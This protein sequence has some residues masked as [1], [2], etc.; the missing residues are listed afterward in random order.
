MATTEKSTGA[1]G[2]MMEVPRDYIHIGDVSNWY[3]GLL[4]PS[5]LLACDMHLPVHGVHMSEIN[6]SEATTKIA[7]VS[8]KR[9]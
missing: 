7:R 5:A 9:S 6:T 3:C 1:L 2:N 8:F 4:L